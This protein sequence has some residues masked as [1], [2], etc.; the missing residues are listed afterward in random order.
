MKIP[1][2]L[3][4]S[5]LIQ[6]I[7][8]NKAQ[9]IA[10]KC[11]FPKNSEP[12]DLPY[13]LEPKIK[14][15]KSWA[16]K[17]AGDIQVQ[18]DDNGELPVTAVAN[19]ANW[20][21]CDMDMLLPGCWKKTIKESGPA[22][23]NRIYHLH[24]HKKRV[25]AVIGKITDIYAQ[26]VSLSDLGLYGYIGS[27]ECLVMESTVKEALNDHCFDMYSDKM[28]NQHSIGMQYIKMDLAINDPNSPAEFVT[29]NKYFMN[30]INKDVATKYGYFWVVYEIKLLEVSAVLWGANELT[31]CLDDEDDMEDDT[32]SQA[33]PKSKIKS[34]PS[35]DTEKN[36]EPGTGPTQLS[37]SELIAKTD[38]VINL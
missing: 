3:T 10:D 20:I 26:D 14:A 16:K 31:P 28:I 34:Q 36:N 27:T 9:I 18:I 32:Y 11:A 2:N 37:V 22:G 4:G 5:E 15:K 6:F 23:K 19:T 17:A 13:V 8:A 21:D 24:D 29:W 7:K 33:P 38:I 25:T 35:D 12:R 30:V 1:G